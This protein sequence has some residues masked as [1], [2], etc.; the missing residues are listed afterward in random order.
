M[1][2]QNRNRC[3]LAFYH[4]EEAHKALRAAR[5]ILER[6]DEPDGADLHRQAEELEESMDDLLGDVEVASHD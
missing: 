1:N 4:L 2:A 6:C 5:R 3:K